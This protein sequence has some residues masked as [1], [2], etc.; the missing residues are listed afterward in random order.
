[1]LVDDQVLVRISFCTV[2]NVFSLQFFLGGVWVFVCLFLF[3]SD[4]YVF[5]DILGNDLK[6]CGFIA[7][8]IETRCGQNSSALRE[9]DL[10]SCRGL[11]WG[12]FRTGMMSGLVHNT[13]MW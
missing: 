7:F 8:K 4:F 11:E 2:G 12:A 9:L 5:F 10:H 6:V 13:R 3:V 1:M